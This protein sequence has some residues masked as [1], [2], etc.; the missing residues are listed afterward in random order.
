MLTIKCGGETK[1][2]FNDDTSE[3]QVNN[4]FQPL[5]NYEN[6]FNLSYSLELHRLRSQFYGPGQK[7][8]NPDASFSPLRDFREHCNFERITSIRNLTPKTKYYRH[9]TLANKA[10]HKISDNTNQNIVK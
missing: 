2:S 4:S 5:N 3:I 7:S 1:S 9:Q 10:S 6:S 8:I